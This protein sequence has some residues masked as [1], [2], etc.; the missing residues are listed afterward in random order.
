M[1]PTARISVKVQDDFIWY[2]IPV[3]VLSVINMENT[4]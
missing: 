1:A 4:L 2:L 3:F